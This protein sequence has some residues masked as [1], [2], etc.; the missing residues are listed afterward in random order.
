[1]ELSKQNKEYLYL[2]F[3]VLIGIGFLLH[4]GQKL[5]GWFGSNKV[6]L[7][8]LMGLAGVI[9]VIAGTLLI[10]GLFTRISSIFGILV[11]IGAWIQ[12]HIP[13]GINPLT[14]GGEKAMLYFAAFL[15]LIAYGS[16]KYSLDKMI[17][18]NK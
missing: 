3:R 15:V 16:G 2:T 7:I 4:G 10:L 12:V 13:R 18:K 8:S 17:Q 14:N 6:E 11:M 9:E 5:F 1:M